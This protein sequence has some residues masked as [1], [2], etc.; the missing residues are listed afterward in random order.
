M[1]MTSTL[2]VC[3]S[4]N[5][6][7][8]RNMLAENQFEV[9]EELREAQ[10]TDILSNPNFE[11]KEKLRKNTSGIQ[12]MNQRQQEE[13]QAAAPTRAQRGGSHGDGLR[14]GADSAAPT[15]ANANV[16]A[17]PKGAVRRAGSNAALASEAKSD[18]ATIVPGLG[19]AGSG[20]GSRNTSSQ[21]L[22][23]VGQRASSGTTNLSRGNS[24]GDSDAGVRG[25][26]V[27]GPPSHRR[28]PSDKVRYLVMKHCRFC[29]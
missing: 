20:L 29:C 23:G 16:N 17:F 18:Q 5:Q 8:V 7:V 6:R 14:V 19:V 21:M 3:L 22:A 9:P 28:V 27:R 4:Y 1:W 11:K 15:T 24:G 13:R 2:C 26:R 12:L 10:L 25:D